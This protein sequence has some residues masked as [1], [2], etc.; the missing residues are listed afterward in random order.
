MRASLLVALLCTLVPVL[1]IADPTVPQLMA[2]GQRAY[3]AGD[4]DT[5]KGLFA[6]VLEINPQNT[7]AIQ[8]LRNIRL[9]QAGVAATPAPDPI[10]DLVIPKI[11]FK[12]AT[13]SS[14]LDFFKQAAA[15]QSVTVSFVPNLP[16]PQMEKMVTLNLAQIPFLDALRYLCELNNAVFKVEPYAIVITP[17]P[18]DASSAAAPQ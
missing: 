11:Q 18:A 12:D 5:A 3:I 14:A 4:Y 17:V 10:K 13:F 7:V 9:A 6:Q 8:F 16:A 15:K 1:A 2:Q